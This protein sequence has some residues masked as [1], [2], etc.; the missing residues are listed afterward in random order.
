VYEHSLGRVSGARRQPA[1]SERDIVWR[2][3]RSSVRAQAWPRLPVSE[4]WLPVDDAAAA[5]VALL[6]TPEPG[7]ATGVYH[8]AHNGEVHL[9]RVRD[10][11]RR[12][13]QSLEDLPL[14]EWVQRVQRQ[15]NAE[16]EATLSFF[17][18]QGSSAGAPAPAALS[19]ERARRALGDIGA[20]QVDDALL[21]AYCRSALGQ[22]GYP[23]SPTRERSDS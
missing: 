19:T 12:L 13:G 21:L 18:L 5:V 20:A 4:P 17:A 2:I 14:D 1:V 6:L 15:Q 3:A 22:W 16:D 7:G 23:H 10:A 8:L 9:D 11:L